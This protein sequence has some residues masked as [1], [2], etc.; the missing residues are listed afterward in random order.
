MPTLARTERIG[1]ALG[2]DGD[3]LRKLWDDEQNRR[4]DT[5]EPAAPGDGNVPSP[6]VSAIRFLYQ[7]ASRPSFRVLTATTGN[8]LTESQL[9]DFFRGIRLPDWP[10]L[11]L[12]VLALD[13]EP[14]FFRPM[15][16]QAAQAAGAAGPAQPDTT[17][18]RVGGLMAAFGGVLGESDRH[19]ASR[20]SRELRHRLAMTRQ[21]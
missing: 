4:S 15:W 13:G 16:E 21:L 18:A 6:L 12:L 11:Q 2:A 5:G 8:V 20:R 17:Q 19:T 9:R 3:V 14:A 1:Q 7:R 10:T